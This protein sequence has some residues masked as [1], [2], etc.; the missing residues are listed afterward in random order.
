MNT[1]GV[2]VHTGCLEAGFLYKVLGINLAALTGKSA[3]Q[4]HFTDNAATK[5]GISAKNN[6]AL[7]RK[8]ASC[9]Y[10]VVNAVKSDTGFW[11]WFKKYA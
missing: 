5:Y 10:M 3:A 11:T 1:D 4:W 2:S 6:T 8:V 7:T 9:A